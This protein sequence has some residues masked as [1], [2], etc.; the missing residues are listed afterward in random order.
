MDW[1]KHRS[2]YGQRAPR[3][4]RAGDTSHCELRVND[5]WRMLI[6]STEP[7][8]IRGGCA[9]GPPTSQAL[10]TPSNS[11][12]AFSWLTYRAKDMEEGGD[13]GWCWHHR[14]HGIRITPQSGGRQ[15]IRH[16]DSATCTYPQY[17]TYI[18]DLQPNSARQYEST[19]H[20]HGQWHLA[21]STFSPHRVLPMEI[22]IITGTVWQSRT[23]WAW[24]GATV[25][26]SS[27]VLFILE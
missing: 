10:A 24:L 7:G 18:W 2:S 13:P 25:W 20:Q 11:T 4:V 14:H 8:G 9:E 19:R 17:T 22:I 1:S 12:Y 27:L 26:K 6:A 3:R 5:R 16:T 21:T 23:H 15:R